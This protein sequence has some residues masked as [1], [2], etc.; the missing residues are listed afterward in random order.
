MPQN[1]HIELF[2]KRCVTCEGDGGA[3]PRHRVELFP[4]A[5]AHARSRARPTFGADTTSSVPPPRKQLVF[6]TSPSFFSHRLA[7][8]GQP[9]SRLTLSHVVSVHDSYGRRLDYYEKKRKKEAREPHKRSAVAK[10]LI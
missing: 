4:R 3:A 10:K 9:V 7:A 2:Q 8:G 6:S 1:E 5:R